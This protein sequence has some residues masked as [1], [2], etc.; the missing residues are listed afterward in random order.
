MPTESRTSPSVTPIASLRSFGTDACMFGDLESLALLGPGDIAQ[1]HTDDEW[2][3]LDQLN[4]GAELYTQLI[5][6]WCSGLS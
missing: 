6:R 5:K 3:E 4:R 2:I 1:A